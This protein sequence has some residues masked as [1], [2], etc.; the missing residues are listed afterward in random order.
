[1]K[2]YTEKFYKINLSAEYIEDIAEKVARYLNG[3]RYD[4]QD[5]LSLVSPTS[6]G[7]AY[8]YALR[9]EE[10]IQRRQST[11]GKYGT[12]GR[13]GQSGGRGKAINQQE[14]VSISTQ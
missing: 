6:V 11:R 2:E 14:G 13:G 3:L 4:I 8:L 10:R 9:E 1:M 12:R 5:E 7:E